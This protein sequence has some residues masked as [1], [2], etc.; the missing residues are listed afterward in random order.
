M[1]KDVIYIDIEDDIT[2]VIDKLKNSS[3]KIVALV[4]PKGN[5]VLQSVV[6]LKL[7]KRA[8]NNA[9]KQ[10]VVVTNNQALTALAGGLDLYVA[11]NL[12]SKPVLASSV[13]EE[14]PEDEEAEVS[15]DA[16]LKD[17]G[18]TVSLSDDTDGVS[19]S[20]EVELSG[21]ELA[22]LE[23]EN[24]ADQP[25]S[26]VAKQKSPKAKAVPN[27]DAFRKKILIGGGVAL[28][29]LIVLVA[30]FGRAKSTIVVRAE[31]TPV[32]VAIEAKFNANSTSSDTQ[33]YNL[34]AVFQE[35]KQ[36]VSQSFTP[37]GEKD[38]GTK[39]TGTMRFTKCSVDDLLSGT[40][41]TIP[42]G[43]GVSSNGLTF[44][45]QSAV[46][47]EPSN[48]QGLNN[49][50]SNKPSS[51]VPVAAQDNGDKFNLSA[52]NYSVSGFSA[53]SGSGSQMTGG[54]SR[55]VKV[56][57]Q[58]DIDKA[59]EAL[60]QQD[61]NS[62]KEELKKA[63]GGGT[64]VLEDSF[65]VAI[66]NAVSE[67]GLDQQANDAKLTAEITY[68]LLGV[69][70]KDI[71]EALDAFVVTQMNDKDRQR[72]YDNGLKNMKLE[73]VASDARTATY[74]ITSVAQYG[75]SLTLKN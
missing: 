7:L 36:T 45:T 73:K 28:L 22:E 56:V 29:L 43:T 30:V 4:P 71:G 42:A 60:N 21:D 44:I 32:D 61:T 66:A 13:V 47:V 15:D 33:T 18:T 37:T 59:Q 69:P 64:T 19:D 2:A 58:Q 67:P 48:Y 27:F 50:K 35:K 9:G 54:T 14:L 34:K 41:T 20:D 63:M 1:K 38:L 23:A 49:C 17:A 57:T 65:S 10:P 8:A 25:S 3:E 72:V 74:K 51:A 39:A 46:T 70:S 5:A 26:G 24:Q 52:R 16:E 6:N 68:T 40:N 31:T 12:Q 62:V 11:K 53:I 55:I 75:P